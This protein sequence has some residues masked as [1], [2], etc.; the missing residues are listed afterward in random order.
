MLFPSSLDKIGGHALGSGGGDGGRKKIKMPSTTVKRREKNT[1]LFPP[2]LEHTQ[3]FWD[4]RIMFTC[5]VTDRS[6]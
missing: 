2:F 4:I 1:F 6:K 3:T 5:L